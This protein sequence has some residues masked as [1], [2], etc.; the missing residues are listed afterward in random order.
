M[1]ESA[2]EGNIGPVGQTRRR[3][4]GVLFLALAL[5]LMVVLA[6]AGVSRWWRLAIF[7]FLW[8]GALG[9][10]QAQARTCVAFAARGACEL[11]DGS[12]RPLDTATAVRMKVRARGVMVRSTL[13]AA[14][15]T[16]LAVAIG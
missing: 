16:V 1:M 8:V 5:L 10:I 7:P 14:V 12:S 9:L 6:L 3:R 2:L 4:A 11:D 13:L 15:V